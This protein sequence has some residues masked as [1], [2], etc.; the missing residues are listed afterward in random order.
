M[1][2]IAFSLFL[3]LPLLLS[4]CGGA[5]TPTPTPKPTATPTPTATPRPAP[6]STP[7]TTPGATP[8]GIPT[9]PP[10]GQV[11]TVTIENLAFTPQTVEIMNGGITVT[12]TNRDSVTHTVTGPDFDSGPLAPGATFTR[13]FAAGTFSY[14]CTIHPTMK[15]M[16]DVMAH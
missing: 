1:T 4:A 15:G 11:G 12:W 3:V 6:T 13:S 2:K 10:G 14:G 16:V 9:P 5:A 8:A 7:A